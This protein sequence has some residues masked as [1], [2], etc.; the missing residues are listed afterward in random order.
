MT[1]RVQ[2]LRSNVSGSRP[3]GR[4]PGEIYVNWAD[5]QIGVINSSNGAQD[6]V[7]VRFFSTTANYNTGDFVIQGGQLY[8]AIAVSPAGAF[9]PANWAQIGGSVGIGVAP[10]NPQP[11]TLWW[12][13][14]S[15][16][17]FVW[18]NDGDTSQWVIANN[19]TALLN[20]GFLPL[21]GGTLTGP[22]TLAGNPAT[23]LQATP[24]QYV[25]SLPV[26]MNDNRIINGDMRIDQRNNGALVPVGGYSI[27][28]W[29]IAMGVAGKYTAQRT[30]SAAMA[31]NGFPYALN[32]VSTS[33]YSPAASDSF[34]AY[35][36]IE[37]DMASDFAWGTAGAQPVTL[38]FWVNL[39]VAGTYSGVIAN[40]PA[41][42]TRCY[43]FS[44]AA[45]VGWTKVIITIPGDTAGTWVMSGN[46]AALYLKLDLGSGSNLR[47]PAGAWANGN[48]NGAIGAVGIVTTNA[49]FMQ[50]TGVKLEIGSVA[51][52]FNR[53]TPAK[54]MVDCQRYFRF[55][56]PSFANG[57]IAQFI[58]SSATTQG[59][60]IHYLDTP[61][62]SSP[63]ITA[64]GNFTAWQPSGGAPVTFSAASL[65]T[66]FSWLMAWT[67]TGLAI[68]QPGILR[69]A[70]GTAQVLATAEL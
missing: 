62:R 16:Q 31:A 59:F 67:A 46:A 48:Y 14:V 32:F 30:A 6:F 15:G 49:A 44:F 64:S 37:A 55:F 9:V 18:Y 60:S 13:S 8:R 41:P 27:D 22:L 7:A 10:S 70:D 29:A 28:R 66:N 19:A 42:P 23:A 12:D 3:T 50:I 57:G 20:T 1:G 4:Q 25:D 63:T 40:A 51:T 56:K 54:S 69:D 34:F 21:V 2:A 53:Q 24:K 52:P 68:A 43:P 39:S 47:A 17:L 33:A 5:G 35:Q 11:G 65:M 36:A 61:M 38:S 58:G 26:A 45:I